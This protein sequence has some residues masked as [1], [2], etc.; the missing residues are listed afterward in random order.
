MGGADARKLSGDQVIDRML[1]L[2]EAMPELA[3]PLGE[4]ARTR[5]Y[6]RDLFGTNDAMR[7]L[8]AALAEAPAFAADPPAE[9]TREAWS[10]AFAGGY[11][12][13]AKRIFQRVMRDAWRKPVERAPVVRWRDRF[14]PDEIVQRVRPVESEAW[15]PNPH[16]GTTTFQRFQGD[17]L[18]P[19]WFTSDTHG[20]VEFTSVDEVAENRTFVP[21]TTLSY[22][23]WPWAWLE[24]EKGVYRWDIVDGALRTA[25]ERGQTL[26]TR[27]QPYTIRVEYAETPPRSKRHPPERSVNVPDWYWDTGAPWIDKGPYAEHEPDSNDPLYLEHFGAF[28]R[29]FAE[30]YD[31]HPDLESV[32]MAYAGFWGESGGNSTPEAAEKLIDIYLES[33]KRTQLVSMLGTPGCAHAAA[34]TRDGERHVGWRADCFGDLRRPDV[35]EVP[36][37]LCFNHTF[38]AYPK[39]IAKGGVTDAWRRAPVT[40]ETC[41]NV[42]TWF[43]S[44]YDLDTIIREGYRYHM[45]V[46]MPK[47]VYF[48]GPF[49][50]RL[51]EFDKR[52]GYRYALRQLLMPLEVSPGADVDL[53]FFVDNVGC[54]PI[55]R[56]YRLAVRFRQGDAASVVMLAQDIREWMPGHTWFAE[57]IT[58]PAGLEKGEAAFDLAIVDDVGAPKVWFAI[59]DR[60]DDGWHSLTSVD[61]V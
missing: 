50:E 22:C 32:D 43:L 18:Y 48:P 46:F 54:A 55:Y 61:V 23:R 11:G 6:W 26:Q 17:A 10:R 60:T 2:V 4:K 30:R 24:P 3:E 51:I 14:G 31:G 56:P 35:P 44:E 7:R 36:R 47:S 29:A 49:R 28:I 40:M 1:S 59:D 15:L 8:A 42:A 25:R 19:A 13:E 53:E 58:V 5:E 34:R 52:I 16:R 39:G 37:D 45:S 38:D 41:G 20:P 9:S 33:F 12:D 57:K 27:F 21:R